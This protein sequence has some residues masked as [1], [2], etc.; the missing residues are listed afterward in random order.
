[1]QE[2]GRDLDPWSLLE[3][4]LGRMD[5]LW[6]VWKAGAVAEMQ[7][8]W[9]ARDVSR[10]RPVRLLPDGPE[11]LAAGIDLTGSLCIRLPDG[12][13]SLARAG[14]LLFLDSAASQP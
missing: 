14:E 7:A 13:E 6:R 9:S 2:T 11:G 8:A 1:L 3:P 12:R 5:E 4:I 10:G